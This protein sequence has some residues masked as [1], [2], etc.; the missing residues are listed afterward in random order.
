MRFAPAVQVLKERL[1]RASVQW[2]VRDAL[3]PWS[4]LHFVRLRRDSVKDSFLTAIESQTAQVV[5]LGLGYVGLPVACLPK[6][7]SR[8]WAWSAAKKR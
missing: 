8:W 5:V 6:L 2:V 4:K 3:V 1:S 7:N